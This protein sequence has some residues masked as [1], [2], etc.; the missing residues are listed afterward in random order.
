MIKLINKTLLLASAVAESESSSAA[1]FATSAS[2][3][4]KS[5]SSISYTS[6]R[7]NVL[8]ENHLRR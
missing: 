8:V 2:E 7:A 1:F 3:F 4:G 5:S 6:L